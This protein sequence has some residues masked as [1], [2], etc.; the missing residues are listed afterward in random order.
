MISMSFCIEIRRMRWRAPCLITDFATDKN[1][2]YFIIDISAYNL[3]LKLK[4]LK[5]KMLFSNPLLGGDLVQIY[6]SL[7]SP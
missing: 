1:Q 3:N 2:C 5:F 6:A 4:I 7:V